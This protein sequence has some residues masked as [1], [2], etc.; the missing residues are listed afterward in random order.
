MTLSGQLRIIGGQWRGRK[1]AIPVL[2]GLRP[3]TDRIRETVFNWLTPIIVGSHCLDAFAGSGALGFEALSRG[4]AHA[5]LIDQSK[6]AI[7]SL[8]QKAEILKTND[9]DIYQASLPEQLKKPNHLF[10]IVFLDPPFNS[11]LLLPMCFYLEKNHL[12]SDK[13]FIYLESSQPIDPDTLPKHW[14]VVKSKKTGGVWYCLAK[15]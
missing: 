11:N 2:P 14:E 8:K 10:D 4:A 5:T 13:A 7:T 3:T 15:R 12:L 6:D 9:V 1:L